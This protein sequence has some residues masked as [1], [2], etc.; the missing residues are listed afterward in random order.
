MVI[1]SSKNKFV[2][3]CSLQHNCCR[4]P[5][6]SRPKQSWDEMKIRWHAAE[7]HEKNKLLVTVLHLTSQW[8]GGKIANNAVIEHRHQMWFAHNQSD[9]IDD[10]S[11]FFMNRKVVLPSEAHSPKNC[12]G[13]TI[14]V[15]CHLENRNHANEQKKKQM[16]KYNLKRKREWIKQRSGEKCGQMNSLWKLVHKLWCVEC[17]RFL[18]IKIDIPRILGARESA[19]E[20][21]HTTI[22]S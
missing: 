14:L 22:E 19:R 21:I 20:P 17:K 15:V 9:T 12:L 6:N 3:R 4:C 2:H 11:L 8:S 5:A 13:S 18:Q 16:L 1:F 7:L 10:F